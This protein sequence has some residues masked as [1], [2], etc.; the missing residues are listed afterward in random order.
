MA[1]IRAIPYLLEDR[2]VIE[3]LVTNKCFFELFVGFLS[4]SPQLNVLFLRPLVVLT[5]HEII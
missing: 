2:A 3:G 4:I 5:A 1:V